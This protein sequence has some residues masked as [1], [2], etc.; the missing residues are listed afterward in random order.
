[1]KIIT[2][3]RCKEDKSKVIVAVIIQLQ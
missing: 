1:V 2:G 3:K